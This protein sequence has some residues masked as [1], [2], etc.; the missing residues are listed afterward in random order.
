L[1]ATGLTLVFAIRKFANFAHGEMMTFGAYM[2]F[3][4]NVIL[5]LHLVWGFVFAALT[6]GLLGVGMELLVFRRLADRGAVSALVASIGI[7]LILQ[8][9]V[10][11]TFGTS[12]HVYAIVHESD[13][14]FLTIGS[15][16]LRINLLKGILPI[17]VAAA[18]ILLLHALFTRT[19]LGK[20]MR[21]TADN[22][23]LARASGIRIR[24]VIHTTWAISGALGGLAGVLLGIYTDVR[25]GLGFQ[26]LLFVFAAVIVGGLGSPYGA[27]L[28][29]LIVGLAIEVATAF[30]AWLERPG[31]L[32]LE[33]ATQYRPI[34]AFVI[35]ILTLL[36]R[37]QGL[38]GGKAV[39]LPTSS[40]R[41]HLPRVRWRH[42]S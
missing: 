38:A 7:T 35:M 4:I 5:G 42:G 32:G 10:N 24:N 6:V 28:G 30:L 17:S 23:D 14:V 1:G 16:P 27:M 19:I 20:S 40:R 11:A 21:A 36:I 2:A 15:V 22:P 18:M 37:P 26:V 13:I 29:G 34:A 9:V 39:I 3:M 31:V 12:P 41:F 33:S 25:L 8:N